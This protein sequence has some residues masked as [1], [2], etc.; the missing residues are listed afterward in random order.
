MSVFVAAGAAVVL[1]LE[2]LLPQAATSS[3][4]VVANAASFHIFFMYLVSLSCGI[5]SDAD[6]ETLVGMKAAQF[7]RNLDVPT[8]LAT[9]TNHDSGVAGACA[10]V[11]FNPSQERCQSGRMGRPAK[12]L[13]VLKRTV[14]S[15]PTLSAI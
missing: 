7:T 8:S 1:L 9:H 4:A 3:E 13:S 10:Q 14:G 6:E 5:A 2:L 12:A 11:H 15:N